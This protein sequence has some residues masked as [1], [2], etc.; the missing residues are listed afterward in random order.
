MAALDIAAAAMVSVGAPPV[1][2]DVLEEGERGSVSVVDDASA[3]DGG[4]ARGVYK[5]GQVP[6]HELAM[7]AL[8]YVQH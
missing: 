1:V 4:A 2:Q 8:R 7:K 6:H 5:G 3:T